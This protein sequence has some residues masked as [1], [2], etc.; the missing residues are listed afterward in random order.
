MKKLI[1]TIALLPLLVAGYGQSESLELTFTPDRPGV[2]TGTSVVAHR[3]WQ[4]E[5][6]LQCDYSYG[7]KSHL[8]PTTMLRW[9][10][11]KGAE[12][13]L[14]YDGTLSETDGWGYHAGPL[15]LGTKVALLRESATMPAM[16][17]MVNVAFPLAKGEEVAPSVY[18]LAD[19]DVASW[20]NV[21]L[22]VGAEWSTFFSTAP[23]LFLAACFGFGITDNLGAFA[24]S[25][26]YI[27]F[28]RETTAE[29]N[30]DF[31]FNYMLSPRVQLDIY[32]SLNLSNPSG[33]ANIGFGV[34]WLIP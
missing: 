21:G 7:W 3:A 25:Y 29:Y 20:L 18:L 30:A 28:S 14:Q 24:E 9:G 13:R 31:G 32:S 2:A 11:L 16:S 26:N 6:G 33:S 10:V 12:L 27:H 34:A 1:A 8:L 4:W 5:S 15:T 23:S 19:K 22:N 17:L